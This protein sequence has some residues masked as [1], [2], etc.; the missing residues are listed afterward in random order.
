ME[1][2]AREMAMPNAFRATAAAK[3]GSRS[4]FVNERSEPERRPP[5]D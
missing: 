3:I 5:V 4:S 1:G 2:N